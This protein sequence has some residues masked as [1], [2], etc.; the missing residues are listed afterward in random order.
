[1]TFKGGQKLKT[2]HPENERVKRRYF[3]FLKE[4]K[5]CGEA[6]VD[7]VAKALNRLTPH[8]TALPP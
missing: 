2:H 1:V 5:R 4:A 6:S 3:V 7:A 8:H